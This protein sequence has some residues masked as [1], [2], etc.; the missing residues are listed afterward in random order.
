MTKH[1]FGIT[2]AFLTLL[3]GIWLVVAPFALAYQPAGADWA[4]PT[5]VDVWTGVVLA[6]VSLAGGAAH[7][8]NLI[9]ELR[10]RGVVAPKRTAWQAQPAPQP[11]QAS[12]ERMLA[13][14]A[15]AMLKDLQKGEDTQ[16]LQPPSPDTAVDQP[17]NS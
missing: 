16:Q 6:V 7:T 11:S 12:L 14:L 8:G 9:G 4:D 10:R 3:A 1:L 2:V 15:A 17:A 5:Y 13:P